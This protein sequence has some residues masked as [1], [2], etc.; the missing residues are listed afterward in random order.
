VWVNRRHDRPGFG[1]TPP[2]AVK[3]NLTVTDMASLA[4]LLVPAGR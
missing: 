4:T 3:P 2:A 1:A